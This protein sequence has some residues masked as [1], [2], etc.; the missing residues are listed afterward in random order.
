LVALQ[1][2]KEKEMRI[3]TGKTTKDDWLNYYQ[4]GIYVNVGTSAIGFE[5]PDNVIYLTSMGGTCGH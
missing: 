3:V 5:N 1:N 2:Q 4:E